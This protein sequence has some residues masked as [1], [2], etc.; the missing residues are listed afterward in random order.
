MAGGDDELACQ[1]AVHMLLWILVPM[2]LFLPAAREA[3]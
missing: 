3:P 1:L 2:L